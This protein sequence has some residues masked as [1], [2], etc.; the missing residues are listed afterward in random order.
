MQPRNKSSQYLGEDFFS[1]GAYLF[2]AQPSIHQVHLSSMQDRVCC[3]KYG[4]FMA[5]DGLHVDCNCA[6]CNLSSSAPRAD[7]Q[8]EQLPKHTRY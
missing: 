8:M 6:D 3:V 1:S 5:D 7:T 4:D 2:L